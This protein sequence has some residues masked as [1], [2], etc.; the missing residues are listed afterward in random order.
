MRK[1]LVITLALAL[2]AALTY[3]GAW[4]WVRRPWRV[5]AS[6][7]GDTLTLHDL[8]IRVKTYCGD[9]SVTEEVRR[10]MVRAW[11]AKQV[12]LGE[13][14]RRSVSLT[15]NDEDE[16]NVIFAGWLANQGTTVDRFF[17]EGPLP[18]EGK[19]KDFK[20]GLLVHA[21][22]KEG[23]RTASF[24]DFYRSI[25]EKVVV[26][27]SEFPELERVDARVP[28]YVGL[29]GWRPAR[30]SVVAAG[31]VVTSAELDLRVRNALDDFRRRGLAPPKEREASILPMLRRHEA[32]AWIVKA[33][34]RAEAT[35]RGFLV[36]SDDEKAHMERK[37]RELKSYKLTVGQFFKE[38][39][40]PEALKWDDFRSEI[41]VGKFT[42]REI[43]DKIN[44]TTQEIE[45]RMAELRKRAAEEAARGGK[46]TV[47]S[48]RKTVIDQLHN[49]RYVKG[50]RE[51]FRSLF[52]SARVW[53]PEFPEMEHV[54][55]V[56]LPL[57]E[58]NR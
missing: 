48:D 9:Q 38:G 19:R 55:G 47:R 30:V 7:D 32:Q 3:G 58:G 33:V 26:Q 14:V 6:V 29:W 10:E 54:N 51:L 42:V 46:A 28:L 15:K 21:L 41:R 34:M 18:E 53:S 40:L 36:T 11:I 57:K 1:A 52:D 4:L 37:A 45:A 5:V 49:E 50:F 8:D 24:Q 23:L 2:L 17:S 13:A 56:S 25:R 27:C 35:R 39:V 43:R 16:V 44:V 12:L 31:Q 20:E 22:V